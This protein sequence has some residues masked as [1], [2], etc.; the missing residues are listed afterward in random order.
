MDT[1]FSGKPLASTRFFDAETGKEIAYVVLEDEGDYWSILASMEDGNG[2]IV[3]TIDK[4]VMH[5]SPRAYAQEM[6]MSAAIMVERLL[7]CRGVVRVEK[8]GMQGV[9]SGTFGQK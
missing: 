6:Y 8:D 5:N 7:F 1:L 3:A 9:V 4:D 2:S